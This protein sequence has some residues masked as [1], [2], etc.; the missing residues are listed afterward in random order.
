MNDMSQK[1]GADQN[2]TLLICSADQDVTLTFD[3][4]T[5][6]ADVIA[7]AVTAL[8]LAPSGTY[9]LVLPD[10]PGAPLDKSRPL[11]SFQLQD[12]AKLVLTATAGGV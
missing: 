2:V 1:G 11:V 9:N 4:T 6:I 10:K 7:A 3:K 8:G 12:G 5:K